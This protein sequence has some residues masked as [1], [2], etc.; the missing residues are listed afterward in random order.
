MLIIP[1][2]IVNVAGQ[3]D[4]RKWNAE[5][6]KLTA[7]GTSPISRF[8]DGIVGHILRSCSVWIPNRKDLAGRC[9]YYHER[10]RPWVFCNWCAQKVKLANLVEDFREGRIVRIALKAR[11]V[12]FAAWP[13][14][15]VVSR[16]Q[17]TF[18]VK[19]AEDPFVVNGVVAERLSGNAGGTVDFPAKL[20]HKGWIIVFGAI[21][22]LGC[23]TVA[24]RGS[25][26]D[27]ERFRGLITDEPAVV[28]SFTIKIPWSFGGARCKGTECPREIYY[29]P[30]HHEPPGRHVVLWYGISQH[31]LSAEERDRENGLSPEGRF[32]RG[33]IRMTGIG[34][35]GMAG[36]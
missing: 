24:L 5:A 1:V 27:I 35:D 18:E 19:I 21:E 2:K 8:V 14:G 33:I 23:F 22:Q 17:C 29:G 4:G 20:G 7:N 12:R 30:F 26:E 10:T 3:Q 32:V 11:H 16:Q 6:V 15:R 9:D 36:S 31:V 34:Y 25:G 13:I 28:E